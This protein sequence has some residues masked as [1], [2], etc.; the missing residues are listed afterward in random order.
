MK[1]RGYF[2]HRFESYS[3][4]FGPFPPSATL[5][6]SITEL[7][8]SVF[9]KPCIF[10]LTP[11]LELE[12]LCQIQPRIKVICFEKCLALPCWF[13]LFE[14]GAKISILLVS[15]PPSSSRS[16][17]QGI[18]ALPFPCY[19]SPE[20]GILEQFAYITCKFCLVLHPFSRPSVCGRL[21]D[22]IMYTN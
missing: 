3:I 17:Q 18:K 6:F 2:K 16:H 11:L 7:N 19:S 13:F 20:E 5:S 1:S 14:V 9:L 10:F 8:A 15:G 4:C 12:H 21:E 22:K